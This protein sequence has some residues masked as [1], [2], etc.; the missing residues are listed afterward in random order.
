[1]IQDAHLDKVLAAVQSHTEDELPQVIIDEADWCFLYHLSRARANLIEWL[2]LT[3]AMDVLEFGAE[4]GALTGLLSERAGSVTA[5]ELDPVKVE[6]SRTRYRKRQNIRYLTGTLA[7]LKEQAKES[8]FD[9]IYLIGSLPL[10]EAYTEKSGET[11]YG[12]LLSELKDF[13]KPGGR[14]I[15]A[16][17]NRF[18]LK[19]FAGCREDYFGA[20]FTGLEDY[21]YHKGMRTFGKKELSALLSASGFPAFQFYYP[22]PDYRL[23]TQLF[24]EVQPP[25]SGELNTNL[26][27]FDQDRYVFFDET[28]VFDSLLKEGLFFE[29]ANSFLVV[30]GETPISDIHYAKYSAERA[31]RFSLRTDLCGSG[32]RRFAKKTALTGPAT[33]HVQGIARRYEAL[34]E[35]YKGSGLMICPCT[36]EDGGVTFPFVSGETL[37][38][39]IERLVI[40]DRLEEIRNLLL[41]YRKK[42]GAV[43]LVPFTLTEEFTEVFGEVTLPEG[44]R[45]TAVSDMDLIFSNILLTKSGAWTVIDYEWTFLFPVP[46]H[47]LLYRAWFFA[48]HQIQS[49]PALNLKELLREEGITE[50]EVAQYERMERHFQEYVLGGHIPERDLLLPIGHRITPITD[51]DEAYRKATEAQPEKKR[52]SLFSKHRPEA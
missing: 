31:E 43:S 39:K 21:Y 1:M 38:Q 37:Q 30:T 20:P 17:P 52:F 23:M 32:E 36:E 47:F 41:E 26:V 34:N 5:L 8:R 35:Y 2:Y 13:L 4:C 33:S 49:S 45:A 18:G 16:L 50:E 3:P 40:E 27:N 11:A 12:E 46:L 42:V 22:Y 29:L 15:V 7:N 28:K 44:L 10:A 6:I 9:Q 48:A 51:M 19:Y 25:R 24:S 14:L